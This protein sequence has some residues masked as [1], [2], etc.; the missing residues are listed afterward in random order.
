MIGLGI[1]VLSGCNANGRFTLHS[2]L[3]GNLATATASAKEAGNRYVI[4]V[5][6]TT[7]GIY[8]FLRGKRIEH[9]R[10]TGH[11]RDGVYYSDKLTIERWHSKNKFHDLQEYFIHYRSKKI[12]RKYQR[13]EGDKQV[14]TDT[15]TLDH[16]GH[17][18]YLTL[19]H[20]ALKKY[21]K[22]P[23]K[24]ITYI[25]AGSEETHGKIPIYISN[26]S[27]LIKQWGG[28][29]GGTLIQMGIHKGIF[30]KGSG[31]MTVLL[32]PQNHPVKFYFSN[33]KTIGTLTGMPAK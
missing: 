24:R 12:V 16:F 20:N 27:K 4:D 33:L 5:K 23:A 2:K 29:S 13:W 21:G 8:N 30:K 11:I 3:T 26:N 15:K 31:S 14:N 6:V 28:A 19:F 22:S 32:D 18:D 10:S 7:R 25:A 9:Y 1:I 17:N